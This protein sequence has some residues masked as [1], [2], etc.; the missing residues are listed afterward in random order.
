MELAN[1][2]HVSPVSGSETST[3]YPDHDDKE[4]DGHENHHSSLEP[5]FAVLGI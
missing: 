2:E 1:K 5:L 4:K 3:T